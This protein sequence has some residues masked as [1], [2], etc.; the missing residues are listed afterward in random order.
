MNFA[1][2]IFLNL[3]KNYYDFF[4][5]N[6][7]DLI[8]HFK[9]I[10]LIRINS[11]DLEIIKNNHVTIDLNYI[12]PYFNKAEY[13]AKKNR[14]NIVILS[15]SKTSIAVKFNDKGNIIAKSS[16]IIEDEELVLKKV[17]KMTEEKMIL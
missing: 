4:E 17:N 9:K 15:D 7:K 5:W 14:E 10:P 2:D 13:Y 8:L 1:H 16:L 3:N 6:K 12:K 11:K